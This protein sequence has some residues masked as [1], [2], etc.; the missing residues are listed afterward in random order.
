MFQSETGFFAKISKISANF[1]IFDSFCEFLIV[2]IILR[3]TKILKSNSRATASGDAGEPSND[4]MAGQ[5][6]YLMMKNKDA[7]Y[8]YLFSMHPWVD[9]VD[10]LLQDTA[11]TLWK[12]IDEYDTER[13]FLPWALRVAYFEVLRWRK[14]MRKRRFLL[15]DELVNKL[16]AGASEQDDLDEARFAALQD[17]L[18]KLPEKQRDIVKRRYGTEGTLKELAGQ[19]NISVHKV[20]HVLDAAR[21]ALVECV[22]KAL[23][24]RGFTVHGEVGK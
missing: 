2:R 18:A 11:M 1:L 7:L 6:A 22:E 5:F 9:E 13:E 24:L 14:H 16:S 15:S 4:G 19:L 20:Y 23:K 17:C 3:E 21:S 8:R 10:D 12:K